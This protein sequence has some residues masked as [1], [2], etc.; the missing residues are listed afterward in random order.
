MT[1]PFD[2][3]EQ[4]LFQSNRFAGLPQFNDLKGLGPSD[5][6]ARQTLSEIGILLSEP[7]TSPQ[8]GISSGI[9]RSRDRMVWLTRDGFLALSTAES[10]ADGT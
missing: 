10:I 4:Y 5:A 2:Y 9:Q 7:G 3:C 8:S 6:F 1:T